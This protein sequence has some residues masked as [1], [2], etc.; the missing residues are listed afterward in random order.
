[1]LSGAGFLAATEPLEDEDEE[2]LFIPKFPAR[3]LED[4]QD[5]IRRPF[6]RD[7]ELSS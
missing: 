5:S 6:Y 7:P 4:E 3:S 1:V 2:K